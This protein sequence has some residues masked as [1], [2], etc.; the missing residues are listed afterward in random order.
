MKDEVLGPI[1]II[2]ILILGFSSFFLL[3]SLDYGQKY[4]IIILFCFVALECILKI[5]IVIISINKNKIKPN[6]YLKRIPQ[7][8]FTSIFSI[9]AFLALIFH[10]IKLF[11]PSIIVGISYL[12][13]QI[14]YINNYEDGI[15]KF[16]STMTI[17]IFYIMT[18]FIMIFIWLALNA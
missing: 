18:L 16:I 13:F 17:P 7:I 11:L 8:I 12:I 14:Y 4:F 2:D 15:L 6:I 9:I 5:I 3:I 10:P 1:I